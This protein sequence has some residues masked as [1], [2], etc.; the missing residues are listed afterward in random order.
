MELA[1]ATKDSK[2][3]AKVDIAGAYLNAL[4]GDGDD[5]YMELS[6]EMLL[7]FKWSQC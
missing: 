7:L 1:I 3:M 2:K 6:K 4:I 5:I